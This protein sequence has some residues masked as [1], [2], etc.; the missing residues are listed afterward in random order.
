MTAVASGRQ[1]EPGQTSDVYI[2]SRST[3][4]SRLVYTTDSVL[5]EAPNWSPDGSAL[6]LNGDGLL[7]NFD[8]EAGTLDHV[9]IAELPPI[10][11][12]HVLSPDGETIF[13]SANDGR[14]YRAPWHGG[15]AVRITDDDGFF[16]F[17]HG[18]SP[19]GSTLAYIQL[20][21][22]RFSVNG[23]IMTVPTIGGAPSLVDTGPLHTDG[24]E[25][26]PDGE[27]LYYNTESFSTETG[28]AQIARVPVAGGEGERLVTSERVDWFPHVSPDGN[29]A[30]YVSFPPGTQGHPAN[31]G[32][33]LTLVDTNDWTQSLHTFDVF[34]GQ[35]TMNVNSWSPD[36]ESFAFVA[37]P[38]ADSREVQS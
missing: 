6:L 24:S 35:G 9:E 1:L 22:G 13:L 25:Y 17:L 12:D 27:Y 33:E 26:S 34:G 8:L 16:H 11:N 36:S 14:I 3:G 2:Y 23:E 10:N 5:L 18:V 19:D 31:L 29:W 7:W 21:P 20:A 30:V 38:S 32:I 4:E 37:Y 28:H 15:T